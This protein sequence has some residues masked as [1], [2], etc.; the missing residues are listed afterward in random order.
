MWQG[1][2]NDDLNIDITEEAILIC[3]VTGMK[4]VFT[5]EI[6]KFRKA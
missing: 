3:T 5:S 4:V 2:R 6:Q 1:L